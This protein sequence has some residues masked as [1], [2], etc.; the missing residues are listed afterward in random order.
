LRTYAEERQRESYANS[1]FSNT[2]HWSEVAELEN[3]KPVISSKESM[4]GELNLQLD[5]W[6]KEKVS[7][8]RKLRQAKIQMPDQH[9]LHLKSLHISENA[10][11]MVEASRSVL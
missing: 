7:F 9:K 6:M 11:K 8:D 4:L 10:Q 1:S 2:L 3:V 5:G